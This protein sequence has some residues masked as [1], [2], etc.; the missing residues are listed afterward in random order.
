MS[1]KGHKRAH[2]WFAYG[3]MT[4]LRVEAHKDGVAEQLPHQFILLWSVAMARASSCLFVCI[5]EGNG[6]V[7][8][9]DAV[10]HRRVPRLC[11]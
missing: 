1:V 11:D 8:T 3:Y 9:D 7:G 5:S 10:E 2:R 6:G 4:A